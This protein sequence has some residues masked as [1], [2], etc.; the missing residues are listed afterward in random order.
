MAA[1]GTIK[2]LLVRPSHFPSQLATA[3]SNLRPCHGT[4]SLISLSVLYN[5][6]LA[7]SCLPSAS[8]LAFL[9]P[10][11]EALFHS[12]H[13]GTF[14]CRSHMFEPRYFADVRWACALSTGGCW[15][16]VGAVDGALDGAGGVGGACTPTGTPTTGMYPWR[17]RVLVDLGTPAGLPVRMP[18]QKAT[19]LQPCANG[20]NADV[21]ADS[22][23]LTIQTITYCHADGIGQPPQS[24]SSLQNQGHLSATAVS[25]ASVGIAE[26]DDEAKAAT[27]AM[28]IAEEKRIISDS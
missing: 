17:L 25:G 27:R 8:S 11:S 5:V 12:S 24:V 18:K 19:K 9:L 1:V 21:K 6:F 7:C 2:D 23:R 4:S 3:T 13:S 16:R 22:I 15:D 10:S 20:H 28:T 26:I 14:R